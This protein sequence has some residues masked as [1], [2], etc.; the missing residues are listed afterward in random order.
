M[1]TFFSIPVHVEVV[2]I[3][4][5]SA[6]LLKMPEDLH[7]RAPIPVPVCQPGVNFRNMNRSFMQ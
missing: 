5:L 2:S 1:M 6:R 7:S 3:V 4:T